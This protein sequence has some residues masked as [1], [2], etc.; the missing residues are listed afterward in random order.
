MYDTMKSQILQPPNPYPA[1]PNPYPI[2]HPMKP[3]VAAL[4]FCDGLAAAM[5]FVNQRLDRE[6]YPN[7]KY[8]FKE[9]WKCTDS[10]ENDAVIMNEME[11]T[12][13]PGRVAQGINVTARFVED[14]N[15]NMLNGW[16]VSDM[17]SLSQQIFHQLHQRNLAP[18]QW[19]KATREA[20]MYYLSEMYSAFPELRFCDGHW[21]ANRLASRQYSGWYHTNVSKRGVKKEDADSADPPKSKSKLSK[22]RPALTVST[23]PTK[24]SRPLPTPV[25]SVTPVRSPTPEDFEYADIVDAPANAFNTS[26]DTEPANVP[27]AP[28][29]RESIGPSV[30]DDAQ[31]ASAQKAPEL[32]E[33]STLMKEP[34]ETPIDLPTPISL[35]MPTLTQEDLPETSQAKAASDVIASSAVTA[36]APEVQS[37]G[38]ALDIL[39]GVAAEN[40]GIDGEQLAIANPL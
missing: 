29:L 36:P 6:Q 17:R 31:S 24:K 25:R 2:Q 23:Q 15:G 8:W 11:G 39:A 32:H 14:A 1:P 10:D 30:S 22:K 38:S 21:K 20:L 12:K 13:G 5:A 4:P 33:A 27:K 7:V 37:S 19:R 26:D 34:V 9:D 16:R 40:A 28:E 18:E 3:P 35:P